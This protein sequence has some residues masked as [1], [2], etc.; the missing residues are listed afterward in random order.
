MQETLFDSIGDF[1]LVNNSKGQ[2]RIAGTLIPDPANVGGLSVPKQTKVF[3]DRLELA[4]KSKE[5]NIFDYG[6]LI[7][8]GRSINMNVG[9][10]SIYLDKLNDQAVLLKA[11][12]K[13]WKYISTKL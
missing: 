7:S 3:L 11:G 8:I 4:L 1:G 12:P 2:F 9:D 13:Q 5:N 10:F 6:E